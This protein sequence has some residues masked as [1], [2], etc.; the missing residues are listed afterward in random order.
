M[1]AEY[2]Q[3]KYKIISLQNLPRKEQAQT[4]PINLSNFIEKLDP[5]T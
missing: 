3:L 4:S 1:Q 5:S 2:K